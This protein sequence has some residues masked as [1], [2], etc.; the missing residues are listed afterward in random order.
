MTR[1][2]QGIEVERKGEIAVLR[3]KDRAL[4]FY[5][6]DLLKPMLKAEIAFA[7]EAG[8]DRFVL[9]LA[10]VKI[11]DSC[12]VGLVI[13]ANN[14]IVAKRHKPRLAKHPPKPAS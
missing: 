7:M 10:D 14:L 8:C 1:E 6:T 4:N 13:H 12:G 2:T 5:I 9:S 11:I 3:F